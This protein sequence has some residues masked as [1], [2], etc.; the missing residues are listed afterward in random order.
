MDTGPAWPT[1][2]RTITGPYGEDRG[3][4]P[5][6]GVD[7]RAPKGANIYATDDGK[8]IDV[9]SNE[10]GGNQMRVLN[11]DESVSGY[12]H[13]GP[14]FR[15]GDQVQRGQTIG[16]SDGS[17]TYQGRPVTPHLHFTYRPCLT[18]AKSDPLLYLNPPG[19]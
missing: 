18:C 19:R 15:R 14:A 4:E 6:T 7:I 8:V 13:T 11:Q 1:D 17:G 16:H 5:H 12:A 3:G 9:Y 10:R 2:D